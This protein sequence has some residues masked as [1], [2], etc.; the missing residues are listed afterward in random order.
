[1]DLDLR[2]SLAYAGSARVAVDAA[3]QAVEELF[4]VIPGPAEGRSPESITPA[5]PH[6]FD[7]GYG[8]RTAASR[9][10]E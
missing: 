7:R 10:P 8:F 6:L 5:F 2:S 1:V 3:S 4:S 9:L